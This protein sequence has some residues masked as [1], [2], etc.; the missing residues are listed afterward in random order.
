[1][2]QFAEIADWCAK[3]NILA[4]E[5][6]ENAKKLVQIVVPLDEAISESAGFIKIKKR[7]KGFSDFGLI[8]AIILASA[9]SVDHKLLSLDRHF[10]GESDCVV[11][12]PPQKPRKSF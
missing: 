11:L 8:E 2:V 3:N 12:A 7:R 10:M 4:K 5:T 6:I 9:R 1:M